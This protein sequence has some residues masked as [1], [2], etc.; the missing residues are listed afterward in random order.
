M[1]RIRFHRLLT[2]AVLFA[3]LFAANAPA[4]H[5]RESDVYQIDFDGGSVA[6]Y[7]DLLRVIE[8]D[9]NIVL[10]PDAATVK[11]PSIRIKTPTTIPETPLHLLEQV[12]SASIEPNIAVIWDGIVFVVRL[13]SPQDIAANER[14]K[15]RRYVGSYSFADAIVT[16]AVSARDIL[17]NIEI[18]IEMAGDDDML[19][20]RFHEPTNLLIVRGTTEQ[21]NTVGNVLVAMRQTAAREIRRQHDAQVGGEETDRTEEIAQIRDELRREITKRDDMIEQLVAEVR[22]L[23]GKLLEL[24]QERQ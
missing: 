11:L 1:S 19:D 20:L 2:L 13:A 18:A 3:V 10:M 4:A 9:Y 15:H 17:T 5:A 8:P 7:V 23:R 14:R 21:H 24:A 22:E 6:E 12:T 16:D